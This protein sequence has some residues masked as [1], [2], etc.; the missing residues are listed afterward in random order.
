M[1]LLL[2]SLVCRCYLDKSQEQLKAAFGYE[3]VV[4]REVNTDGD[5][6]DT[7]WNLLATKPARVVVR[8][9]ASAVGTYRKGQPPSR[10]G[11]HS[12]ALLNHDSSP[13]TKLKAQRGLLMAIL[14]LLLGCKGLQ[15]A[16]TTLFDLLLQM[17]PQLPG[18]RKQ[19]GAR[20]GDDDE[21]DDS[22]HPL[23]KDW[24]K[25]ISDD[26]LRQG[27][28]EK[29]DVQ[30]DEQQADGAGGDGAAGG[31][32]VRGY[33]IG[34]R[35]RAVLGAP[36]IYEYAT[37]I[38]AGNGANVG[39]ATLITKDAVRSLLV[40]ELGRWVDS[41]PENRITSELDKLDDDN[42]DQQDGKGKKANLKK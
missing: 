14:T 19:R 28:L 20:G 3:C 2:L 7:E 22:D 4:A 30:T 27:Y 6:V 32:K 25:T 5:E 31:G 24:K 42:E 12:A 1:R 38:K 37:S 35:L 33:R 29:V 26:F 34:V 13:A 18:G 10:L 39:E 23:G 8:M 15:I 21:F 17:D 16:E 9:C 40:T 11:A 36:A 41:L